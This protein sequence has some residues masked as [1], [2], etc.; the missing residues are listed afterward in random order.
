M[1]AIQYMV[2]TE[3]SP[4]IVNGD[5][6]HLDMYSEETSNDMLQKIEAGIASVQERD[7]VILTIG[8]PDNY[9][10]LAT[11]PC[12]ICGDKRHGERVEVIGIKSA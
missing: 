2:C 9:E 8:D 12:E 10:G 6:S 4:V 3:C 11:S 5:A 1:N 7:D